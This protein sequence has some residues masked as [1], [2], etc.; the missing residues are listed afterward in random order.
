MPFVPDHQYDIFISYRQADNKFGWVT[1]LDQTLR[2]LLEEQRRPVPAEAAWQYDIFRD[3]TEIGGNAVLGD[4]IHG[5]V[6]STAVL[7]VVMS[8]NY[9]AS[10]SDW[11]AK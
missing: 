1:Q 8:D 9:L 7:V 5:A 4:R 2:N 3:D 6:T 10:D 11:C